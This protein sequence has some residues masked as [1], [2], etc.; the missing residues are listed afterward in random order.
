MSVPKLDEYVLPLLQERAGSVDLEAALEEFFDAQVA[1]AAASK[2]LQAFL[3][4]APISVLGPELYAQ[5]VTRR[6]DAL[7]SASEAYRAALD[8]QDA[9][10]STGLESQRE[11]ARRLLEE[12]T[13]RKAVNGSYDKVEDRVT[14][15]WR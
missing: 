7:R 10:N 1:W 2:E 15:H 3:E 14:L 13:L 11:L 8:A 4:G 9:L 6:R 12:I 5:E